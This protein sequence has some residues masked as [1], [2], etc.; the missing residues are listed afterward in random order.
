MRLDTDQAWCK[1]HPRG[2]DLRKEMLEV[3]NYIIP[4]REHSV[5]WAQNLVFVAPFLQGSGISAGELTPA[6]RTAGLEPSSPSSRPLCIKDDWEHVEDDYREA[7]RK[8]DGAGQ[9]DQEMDGPDGVTF[10]MRMARAI[11][12]ALEV[13]RRAEEEAAEKANMEYRR[14]VVGLLFPEVD[15]DN[16]G[17]S[18]ESKDEGVANGEVGAEAKERES[19]MHGSFTGIHFQPSI[20]K[21]RDDR[22]F[23]TEHDTS[24]G[25]ATRQRDSDDAEHP[26]SDRMLGKE[27]DVARSMESSIVDNSD[28]RYLLYLGKPY[29]NSPTISNVKDSVPRESTL[30]EESSTVSHSTDVGSPGTD[31]QRD[32]RSGTRARDENPNLQRQSG[33]DW[34]QESGNS[35]YSNPAGSC[36]CYCMP[37][38]NNEL[39]PAL[40]LVHGFELRGCDHFVA[41]SYCWQSTVHAGQDDETSPWLIR[42]SEND[43]RAIRAPRRVLRRAIAYARAV[44]IALIWIDQ[45][46]IEQNDPIAKELAIHSMDLVYQRA[47]YPIGLLDSYIT[48]QGELD[49]FDLAMNGHGHQK[50][51]IEDLAHVVEM[52]A[53]DMW[54]TR[55][56]TLQEST[57]TGLRL[58]LLLQYDPSLSRRYGKGGIPGEVC[59]DLQD[60]AEMSERLHRDFCDEWFFHDHE[61]GV[62]VRQKNAGLDFSLRSKYEDVGVAPELKSRIVAATQ[63]LINVCMT[64]ERRTPSRYFR[65]Y[66]YSTS[67]QRYSAA[68]AL[69]ILRNRQTGRIVD[70]VAILGNL[71]SYPIRL[72]TT[73]VES[74]DFSFSVCALTLAIVNGD[75]SLLPEFA[76]QAAG[77]LHRKWMKVDDGFSW[78]PLWTQ[79]LNLLPKSLVDEHWCGIQSVKLTPHGLQIPGWLW[80]VDREVDLSVIQENFRD[81]W[82]ELYGVVPEPSNR[83]PEFHYSTKELPHRYEEEFIQA[84]FWQLLLYLLSIGEISLCE[85]IWTQVRQEVG[86][87]P[88]DAKIHDTYV[89]TD[90]LPESFLR[91]VD[92]TTLRQQANLAG[93]SV[94]NPLPDL[95]SPHTFNINWVIDQVLRHGYLLVG[96]CINSNAISCHPQDTCVLF[97]MQKLGNYFTPLSLL[98]IEDEDQNRWPEWCAELTWNVQWTGRSVGKIPVFR[99]RRLFSGLAI[100]TRF[101]SME[102]EIFLE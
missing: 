20:S 102:D 73:K 82:M 26:P 39:N 9:P 75:M 52:L 30:D 38:F 19:S 67:R 54:F 81:S 2:E 27:Q 78:L 18:P 13:R 69:E 28:E 72:D 59:F 53:N 44:D 1:I 32:I 70:R 77:A 83:D 24:V 80:A 51:Q 93:V 56:W 79:S 35:Y 37:R 17:S 76:D 92:S 31:F 60:L 74:D 16:L 65:H 48:S 98:S 61:L 46:C 90:P 55:G 33:R 15:L 25:S 66:V 36:P 49:A 91:V 43:S 29:H 58:V 3:S 21:E 14:Y 47:D 89:R 8:L 11:Q 42:H 68:R 34:D 88:V 87:R 95:L 97:Q 71:C 57:S 40:R 22:R 41:V 94:A 4:N 45:E 6:S 5:E 62:R 63:R 64:E 86:Q 84:F 85:L 100:W 10:R 12:E 23:R 99:C 101:R 50:H 96:R 7:I